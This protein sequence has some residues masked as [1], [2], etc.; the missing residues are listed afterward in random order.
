MPR[1]DE[2]ELPTEV[3]VDFMLDYGAEVTSI[4]NK[5][6]RISK[7]LESRSTSMEAELQKIESEKKNGKT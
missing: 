3:L 1:I 2:S 5:M 7:V 6:N 4:E